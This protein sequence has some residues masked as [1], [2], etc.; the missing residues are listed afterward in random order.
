MTVST[1]YYKYTA[2]GYVAMNSVPID[3]GSYKFVVTVTIKDLTHYVFS[4]GE[5]SKDFSFEYEIN[6]CE[7]NVDGLEFDCLEFTY[8]EKEHH[9]ALKDLPEHVEISVHLY[10]GDDVNNNSSEYEGKRLAIDPGTY[11]CLIELEAVNSNYKLVGTT[12]YT[13]KFIIVTG[14]P[15]NISTRFA[16]DIVIEYRDAGYN[17]DDIEAIVLAGI[18]D[19]VEC[20]CGSFKIETQNGQWQYSD[21]ML[22]PGRYKI[23]IQLSVKDAA[24]YVLVYNFGGY[25]S[26]IIDVYF[27]VLEPSHSPSS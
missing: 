17:T 12:A 5:A 13:T 16:N 27:R 14:T 4:N 19:Y 2:S 6:P 9:P 1:A 10:W 18:G 24:N 23:Q 7:I 11:G 25:L 26:K 20:L 15:I 22:E 3:V 8:D 21:V